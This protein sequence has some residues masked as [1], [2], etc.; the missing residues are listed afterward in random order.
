MLQGICIDPGQTVVLEKGKSYFLFPN[1]TKHYYVSK[2]PNQNAHKGCF[3]A[4][5]F[6]IIEKEEW[7]QEPVRLS[8]ILDQEKVYMASLI[9]RKPGYKSTELKEHYVKPKATHGHFYHDSSLKEYGGC[10]PLHWF[11]DFVE[12][13]H[14]VIEPETLDFGIE[15]EGSDLFLIENEPNIANY[16]QLSLFD[17]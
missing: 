4:I 1:G 11:T 15:I 17:F 7:L 14:E 10:F 2:F 9:W 5:Y 12:V 8:I 16:V 13:K 6:Q 3:Q